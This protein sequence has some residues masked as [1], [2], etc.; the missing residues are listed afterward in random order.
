MQ[1]DP[2]HASVADACVRATRWAVVQIVFLVS[3]LL[4]VQSRAISPSRTGQVALTFASALL[5][6]AAWQWGLKLPTRAGWQG[7]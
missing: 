3:L 4:L 6:Q 1:S 7:Y 5:T 2:D